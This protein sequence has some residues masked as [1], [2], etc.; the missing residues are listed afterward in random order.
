MKKTTSDLG[1]I[2]WEQIETLIDIKY[3]P[4]LKEIDP[5]VFKLVLDENKRPQV[6]E[7]ILVMLQNRE[8]ENA[9]EEYAEE[10][11]N[12][13]QKVARKILVEDNITD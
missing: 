5:S 9:T 1:Q 4:F 7:S 11:V 6:T 2:D 13:M 12:L 10:I 3:K 8:P